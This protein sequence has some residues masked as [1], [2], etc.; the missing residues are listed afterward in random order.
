MEIQ[1][2]RVWFRFSLWTFVFSVVYDFVKTVLAESPWSIRA[3]FQCYLPFFVYQRSLQPYVA[4]QSVGLMSVVTL[5]RL[6]S[7]F[8]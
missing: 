6:T 3:D 5:L 4:L 8:L 7:L 1:A 2:W